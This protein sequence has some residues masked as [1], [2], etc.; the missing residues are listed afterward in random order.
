ME[1]LIFTIDLD[2]FFASCEELKNPSI[3]NK[4]MVVGAEIN[5]RGIVSAANYEARK[6]GIKSAMPFFKAKKLCSNLIILKTDFEFYGNMSN[7]VF[8]IVKTFS[9][10]LE[11][12][13][14]DEC[15]VDVTRLSSKNK[16]IEIARIIK[17]KIK[18][19]TNL[20]VSIGISTNILLSKIAS[21]IDKPNGIS[22]LYKHEIKNKLWPM[23]LIEMFMLGPATKKILNS[24]NIFTIGELA[25]IKENSEVY[26]T[27]KNKI[28]IS[29]KKNIDR[30]N[31][32]DNRE[33]NVNIGNNKSISKE[34]TFG[35]SLKNIESIRIEL[36]KLFELVL[37][38]LVDNK[39]DG[40]TITIFIKLD[41][42]FVKKTLSKK[43]SKPTNDKTLIW[44]T[45]DKM[46][47]SLFKNGY[48]IKQVGFS[49][50]GL[51]N[52][53]RSYSQLSIN[54][55]LGSSKKSKIDN[56]IYE[57]ETN[58]NINV[59]L[60]SEMKNNKKFVK[61]KRLID[62]DNVKFKNWNH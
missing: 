11:V 42:T 25:K 10:I 60:G 52:K 45:T 37:K 57:A 49:I 61:N 39:L 15:Y 48:S 43:I 14:I 23:D 19:E 56:I 2:A 38:R 5:G 27:L 36:R 35:T 9:S 53:E 51:K 16:P 33:I 54:E 1:K 40:S 18:K 55:S 20:V 47:D 13:S 30:A 62:S 29:F 41:G 59:V 22:T 24:H 28:G 32:I 7:K 8:N 6:Y 17:D 26:E 4:P 21:S 58:L 46:I 12:A 34:K 31:G 3:K 44:S 50:S